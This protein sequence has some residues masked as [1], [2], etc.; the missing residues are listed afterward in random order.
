LVTEDKPLYVED[1]DVDEKHL[2]KIGANI[3]EM[4]PQIN[5]LVLEVNGLQQIVKVECP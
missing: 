5:V 1:L 4:N 3:D 2:E